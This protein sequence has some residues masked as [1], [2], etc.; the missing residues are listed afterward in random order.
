MP[1]HQER[2]SSQD[3]TTADAPLVTERSL[4][5]ILHQLDVLPTLPAVANTV[6]EHILNRDFDHGPLARIIETDPG[7]TLKI[8]E[9]AN[10]AAYG[11]GAQQMTQIEKC[12][13]RLGNKVTQAL[14]LSVLIKDSL[15]TGDK[16]GEAVQK[17]M[18]RHCVA[19]GVFAALI[20]GKAY[21][22]L[23]GEA[24]GAGVMHDIG[25]VFLQMYVAEEYVLVI[26]HMEEMFQEVL[27]AEQE[28]FHTDHTVVGRWIAHKW[29]LPAS[30]T[31]V[32]WLH[33]HSS[34]ALA[35]LKDNRELVAIVALANILAHATLMDEARPFQRDQVR[36]DGYM[37][38]LQ[39]TDKDIDTIQK[40]FGPAFAERAT[41]FNLENDQTALFLSSLQKANQ[42]LLGISLELEQ[43]NTRLEDANRYASLGSKV[44][45]R[46]SK[47]EAPDEVFD[48]IAVLL[49]EGIGVRGGFAYWIVPS[50][51]VMQG[52]VWS[53]SGSQRK[54]TYPLDGDGLPLLA[55]GTTLPGALKAIVM[56]HFER[57]DSAVNAA[58]K[59]LRFKQFFFTQGYC[60]FP[61]VG[62][63]YTGEICI[64]RSTTRPPKMT[65]QEYMG[66]SQVAC[67]ASATLDRLRLFDN[68]QVRA[69]ELSHAL[70]KN[71]QINLQLRQTERLAAV[72][73]LAAGAAHEINNPLA[74]I[75]ARTQLLENREQDER[76]RRDLHQISQQIERITAILQSLMGFARPNA[77]QITRV[78]L[79]ALL[80]KIIGLV[81]AVF[82]AH[83]IPIIR[84]LE[85][86]LPP[87][88]ADT[89]QLEQVFLNLV[90][91]AQHAMEQDGGTLTIMSRLMPDNKRIA[92]S[93]NDTGVGI[94]PENLPKIFDPFFTTKSEGKGT[95]LGLSTAYGIV[96]NHYGEIK[97]GSDPGKGTNI[98][99]LLPV[100]TPLS[101]QTGDSVAA[102][103]ECLVPQGK[104]DARILLVDD[105][106]NIREVLSEALREAGY[107]VDTATNGEEAL[108]ILHQQTFDL[109]L[110][111]IRMPI[112]S[113][114]DLLKL[115]SRT[116]QRPPILVIT[117]LA[118]ND[119][120]DEALRL[121]AS[122]CIRKPF[123]LKN[124]LSEIT[125]LLHDTLP[126]SN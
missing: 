90:I 61:L 16:T 76:K 94:L 107:S 62:G 70:W 1:T 106:Q 123:H 15:I 26:E 24:F 66:F 104:Q 10:S 124:L 59:E 78:D 93:V 42:R 95:G 82:H 27:E 40:A 11:R 80:Q 2:Y 81:E 57:Y 92:V 33:H 71:Q 50:E 48:S 23:V 103:A 84:N 89:N 119:E 21:P 45:L 97:V 113:G 60:I 32:I 101:I 38:L 79:N 9:H 85:S 77:P 56:S 46:L 72:G 99:V 5:S 3:Q 117:G 37:K 47:A 126:L 51:R 14:L 96:K 116:G 58:D 20:A 87:I 35:A 120:I 118:S 29:K 111:D 75:S 4:Q 41:P 109:M 39:L 67:V 91:N 88:L 31:D 28:V 22:G 102:V 19:T 52:L 115:L 64:L 12:L 18:W 44:G 114:L 86:D 110:L 73:Q 25:R 112:R 68:L 74:I 108:Q 13:S 63:D 7:L 125:S 49:Q 36:M 100:T 6:L 43:T 121:G 122:K 53:G 8:I 55:S 30:M 105:E 65:P 98:V 83:K 34:E 54:V 17:N 69:D